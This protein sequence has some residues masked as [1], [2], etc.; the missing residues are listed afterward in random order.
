M[1]PQDEDNTLKRIDIQDQARLG[2]LRTLSMTI[3]GM[4]HRLGRSVVTIL[5]IVV[6][7]AFLMNTLSESM[8]KNSVAGRLDERIKELHTAANLATHLSHAGTEEQVLSRLA[9]TGEEESIPSEL[10]SMGGFS[11]ATMAEFTEQAA[12]AT[13]IVTWLERLNYAQRRRLLHEAEGYGVFGWL[14]EPEHL[15]RFETELATMPSLKLP[16]T[17][18]IL[19]RFLEAWPTTRA[20]SEQVRTGWLEAAN[21]LATS[22]DGRSMIEALSDAEGEFGNQVREA[23]FQ[24]DATTADRVAPQAREML[25][26][27]RIEQTIDSDAMQIAIAQRLDILPGEIDPKLLWHFLGSGSN[28][29]WFLQRMTETGFRADDLSRERLRELSRIYKE[30]QALA[31]VAWVRDSADR[32]ILDQRMIWLIG[33]SLIVCMVGITNAMLMSVTQRFREIATM[34][35]LGALDGFIALAFILEACMLGFFG[36]L[37]G[38]LVGLTIAM[39]RMFG[40]FGSLLAGA[41]PTPSLLLAVGAALFLGVILAAFSTLIPALQAA[42]LAP[43]KAMRVE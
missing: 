24:L 33:V 2:F 3:N 29:S 17:T 16:V 8:L 32:R 26:V 21:R 36:G 31:S 13:A 42:R 22:L 25:D 11:D 30:E 37:L 23:G 27:K 41:V 19:Y 38:A 43:M 1:L 18:E 5:V 28:A 34:K 40:T 4:R 20:R 6:A 9:A 7:I 12:Q 10:Q 14:R 39:S 15:Q 35:C